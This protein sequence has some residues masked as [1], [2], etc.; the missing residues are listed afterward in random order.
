MEPAA[1]TGSVSEEDLVAYLDGELDQSGTRRIEQLLGTDP[2]VRARLQSLERSWRLL[3][4]LDRAVP[5]DSFTRTTLEMVAVS[6]EE[7]VDQRRVWLPRARFQRWLFGGLGVL[8]AAAAGFLIVVLLRPNPNRQLLEDLPILE[9]LDHY[10][11]VDDIKFLRRL[12]APLPPAPRAPGAGAAG[13]S[14]A[15]GPCAGMAALLGKDTAAP[16]QPEESLDR[17]RARLEQ[18]SLT[19]KAQILRRQERFAALERQEQKR[20]RRLKRDLEQAPDSVQL[21]QAMQTYCEW[22]K[23]LPS[24]QRLELVELPLPERMTR[25][26]KLMQDQAAKGVRRPAK[27]AR[28]LET[29]KQELQTQ[30]K[31]LNKRL[32]RQDVEGLFAWSVEMADRYGSRLLETVPPSRRQELQEQ[33]DSVRDNVGRRNLFGLLWM[34]WQW[35]NPGKPP[36]M[37]ENDLA[38]LRAKLSDTTRKRLL[39]KPTAEQWQTV[40]D[41]ISLLERPKEESKPLPNRPE[42]LI[43]EELEAKLALFFEH[44]LNS[45]QQA[46]LLAA[47]PEQM[48]RELLREYARAENFR[49]SPRAADLSGG[50]K[51]KAEG[52]RRKG[53][54]KKADGR[55]GSA[56]RKAEAK[57]KLKEKPK[58]KPETN[59]AGA[60]AGAKTSG[61]QTRNTQQ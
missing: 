33:L 53:E 11:Q 61:T 31:K 10:R 2:E 3:D 27:R 24:Y 47:D 5:D 30:A 38:E 42:E 48:M 55:S 44:V 32:D 56:R 12:V 37:S 23:T 34:Q 59:K 4:T 58:G 21:Q 43:S 1:N 17:R 15:A 50:A 25:I 7:E 57:E 29:A 54:G 19:E 40:A 26:D 36:P 28:S 8:A 60:E 52:G 6:A 41:W 35:A 14:G 22:L 49:A 18:T 45:E 51:S 9:N 16:W 46:R 39:K 20:I 13:L